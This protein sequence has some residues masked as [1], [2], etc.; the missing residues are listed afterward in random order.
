[1]LS[2][3][4]D[5]G[6]T[7]LGSIGDASVL[8]VRH[9]DLVGVALVANDRLLQLGVCHFDRQHVP[10]GHGD[11]Q[12]LLAVERLQAE[13]GPVAL[14]EPP[15]VH[16]GDLLVGHLGGVLSLEPQ[17][18][19]ELARRDV[20]VD[21]GH[22]HQTRVAELDALN[23]VHEVVG[24]LGLKDLETSKQLTQADGVATLQRQV[25]GLAVHVVVEVHG[26]HDGIHAELVGVEDEL[27]VPV[28]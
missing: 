1:M 19:A 2:A 25:V 3:L 20:L 13:Q 4:L 5:L 28:G 14:L 7:K 15:G 23:L 9:G 12:R 27:V 21:V 17:A 22:G 16:G 10:V 11:G 8:P 18:L 6:H 24:V 26:V